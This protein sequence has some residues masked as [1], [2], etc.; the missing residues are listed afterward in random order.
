MESDKSTFE[1][2]VP[3]GN[4][5]K[6]KYFHEIEHPVGRRAIQATKDLLDALKNCP[7]VPT[8]KCEILATMSRQLD[9]L[10]RSI[11]TP[12]ISIEISARDNLSDSSDYENDFILA[13]LTCMS[14][15]IQ[16]SIGGVFYGD[17]YHTNIYMVELGG[18]MTKGEFSDLICWES[19]VNKI[20]S[21]PLK[22][23]VD[24]C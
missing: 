16:F 24:L 14:G 13:S 18:F 1:Q 19:V 4:R 17:T 5:T 3:E 22:V 9:K 10:P 6:G 23:H 7:L 2:V 15:A 21:K 12:E 8:D 20:I 11:L